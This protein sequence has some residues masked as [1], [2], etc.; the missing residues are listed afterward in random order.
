M[1]KASH[2][3]RRREQKII[4]AETMNG[5]PDSYNER[6]NGLEYFLDGFVGSL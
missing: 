1:A 2:T 3:E 4:F 5:F 6:N